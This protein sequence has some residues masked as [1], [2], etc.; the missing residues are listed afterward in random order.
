[1]KWGRGT[2]ILWRGEESFKRGGSAVIKPK[3]TARYKILI[4]KREDHTER[5]TYNYPHKINT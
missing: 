3:L 1:M 2:D 4:T 5:K